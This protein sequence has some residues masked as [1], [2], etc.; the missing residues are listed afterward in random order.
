MYSRQVKSLLSDLVLHD[1]QRHYAWPYSLLLAGRGGQLEGGPHTL[2]RTHETGILSVT[3]T[4]GAALRVLPNTCCLKSITL[5]KGLLRN[6][7]HFI[8][9]P[10]DAFYLTNHDYITFNL[11]C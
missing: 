6:L 2:N 10:L 5:A 9:L 11:C 7:Q 8:V 1:V 3:D 4:V